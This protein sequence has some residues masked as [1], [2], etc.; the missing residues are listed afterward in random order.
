VEIGRD[1]AKMIVED[2]SDGVV[3]PAAVAA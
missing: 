2:V 1:V 3:N